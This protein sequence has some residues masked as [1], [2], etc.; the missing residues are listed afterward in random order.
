MAQLP[1]LGVCTCLVFLGLLPTAAGAAEEL[2]VAAN[3]NDAWSGRLPAPNPTRTEGPFATFVKARDAVR[4]LRKARPEAPVTVTVRGGLYRVTDTLALSAED[5]G[6]ERAPVTWRAMPGETVRLVGGALLTGFQPVREQA[7]LARLDPAARAHV[8]QVS[9]KGAGVSDLGVPTPGA[10]GPRADLVCNHE[11]M[12]LARYPNGGWLQITGIPTG[13]AKIPGADPGTG[14][15]YGRFTYPGDRPARWKDTSDL[16]VHGYWV[17]DWSDQYQRVQK[18]DVAKREVWP[19][20]PYHHYGYRQGQRFYFLNILEELDSPGEWYLDRQTATLYFWPPCPLQRAEVFFPELAKPMV[21]LAGTEHVRLCGLTLECSRDAAVIVSGGAHNEIAG[22]TVRNMGAQTAVSISG[23]DN[24]IRSSDVYEVAGCGIEL[25]GGDRKTLTAARNYALNC[26]VH[27]VGRVFRTYHG[28]FSLNGVGNRIAHC[29]V[30][31]VPHQGI[32]YSGNDHVIEYCDFTRIAQETG[33][34]GVTYTGA[35]WTFMGHE[36]RYNYLHNIHGPGNLGCFTIYPDLPCG[37]IHLHGNVFFDTDQGFYTN[38][39]RAMVIENNIFLRCG[40]TAGFGAW[41]DA[42]M[43][44]EHGAW[45]MV[46]NL[47]AVNYDQPPYVTR[48]P[49]LRQLAADFARGEDH[50]LERELPKDNLVR[51]NVSWGGLFLYLDPLA[52]LDHVRLED[53]VIADD[54]VF[55]GSFDGSGRGLTYHNGDPAI[56]RELGKWGNVIVPGDPGLGDLKTQDFRLSAGSPGA[57]IGF[58]RVPF[59]RM[60]LQLDEYRKALPVRVSEP[61]VVPPSRTFAGELAVRLLPTPQPGQARCVVRYT[62]DGSEPGARSEA[63]T[64]P[65][66]ITATTVVKA[67][68]F[69]A[70]GARLIRSATVSAEYK[71]SPR[72]MKHGGVYLSDLQEREL[73]VYQPCWARDTNYQG[74]PIKLAG[75]EYA[76]GLLLHPQDTKEGKGLGRVVYAL[77]GQL[78]RAR[79]FRATIGIDDSMHAYNKGSAT[80]IVEVHRNGQ[81]ERVFESGV[82]R[83]GDKPQAVNVGIA[84]ADQLRLITT[85]A[86][87]GIACDHAEWADARV[88]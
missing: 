54:I 60:G 48:Y 57:K 15:H 61:V 66:R 31:H 83:L 36:F 74:G 5:S 73:F 33:D 78:R 29:A 4:A 72:V 64:Q 16:W 62:L 47:N 18:L 71:L 86:G 44:K 39:G 79:W 70:D 24:G 7:I 9:L 30:H 13:G 46:E 56:A 26:D 1:A 76:K 3:G 25:G 19:Q 75:V 45:S 10:S 28:A 51:R 50:I 11:Y 17:W 43:F 67:A 34:V 58:R 40:K 77:E 80:F 27:H 35:D 20:P 59:R 68:A 63:Y 8:V 6:T 42:S 14:D 81:W 65:I 49:A 23:S 12:P 32:G 41:R 88:E 38:S 87:D 69:V 22:C 2:W 21:T 52:T 82:L 85:D 37:G 84:G 55:T 53:N